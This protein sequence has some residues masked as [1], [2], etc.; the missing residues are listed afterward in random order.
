VIE[1]ID[2][3]GLIQR[4]GFPSPP[5]RYELR[6]P[7]PDSTTVLMAKYTHQPVPDAGPAEIEALEW[8]FP[9][10]ETTGEVLIEF[11]ST[12]VRSE[13]KNIGSKN[14]TRQLA[15]KKLVEVLESWIREVR[16]LT[17]PLRYPISPKRQVDYSLDKDLIRDPLWLCCAEF[18]IEI[19]KRVSD[20]SR[21]LWRDEPLPPWV[22]KVNALAEYEGA[23][24]GWFAMEFCDD[25]R[26]HIALV[27]QV[28]QQ[29]DR[30]LN[31]N[32]EG[33]LG[34]KDFEQLA[35]AFAVWRDWR[36]ATLNGVEYAPPD[37]S[38]TSQIPVPE[39]LPKKRSRGRPAAPDSAEFASVRKAWEAGNF[40]TYR[41][42]SKDLGIPEP[43]VQR[44]CEI[45]RKRKARLGKRSD[46]GRST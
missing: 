4:L 32:Q 6:S 45:L 39:T 7:P 15:F 12:F 23:Y 11:G 28:P 20:L 36:A 22:R 43:E 25:D 37:H 31:F 10:E 33:C 19:R 18:E 13:M 16:G 9:R 41:D 8:H 38:P 27:V 21:F 24:L 34:V 42:L 17:L 44:I 29:A 3:L 1:R 26:N 14:W 35:S 40:R 46:P 5:L 2:H 30:I